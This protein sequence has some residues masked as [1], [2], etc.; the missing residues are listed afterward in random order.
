M[1]VIEEPHPTIEE[2]HQPLPQGMMIFFFIYTT[3]PPIAV[4]LNFGGWETLFGLGRTPDMDLGGSL[5]RYST[6]WLI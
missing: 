1:L 3:T 2:D 6:D 4:I 5:A